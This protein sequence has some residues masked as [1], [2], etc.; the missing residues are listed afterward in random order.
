MPSYCYRSKSGEV[1][2]FVF[3]IKDDIPKVVR[4]H[5][6]KFE[7]SFQDENASVQA[8]AGWPMTC[9]ASG[10]H[11]YQ[12]GEL[13]AHFKKAGVRT[14]VTKDGDPIYRNAKHRKRALQCRGIHDRNSFS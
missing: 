2:E 1:Q 4:I 6:V 3:S 11:E 7:R 5:G 12:A 13:R 8:S 14:E 10:V 9:V